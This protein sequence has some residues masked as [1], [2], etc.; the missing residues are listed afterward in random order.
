MYELTVVD[1]PEVGAGFAPV[2]GLGLAISMI[3]N[4]GAIYDFF[5]GFFDGLNNVK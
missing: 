1:C 3:G 5:S 2:A 4:S